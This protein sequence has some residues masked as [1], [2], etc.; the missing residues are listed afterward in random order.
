M[1]KLLPPRTRSSE[2]PF[3]NPSQAFELPHKSDDAFAGFFQSG[4]GHAKSDT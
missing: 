2:I 4:V 1:D 3:S